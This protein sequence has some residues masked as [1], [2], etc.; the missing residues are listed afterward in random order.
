MPPINCP[1][2]SAFKT[3]QFYFTS[4]KLIPR[5]QERGIGRPRLF[6]LSKH[7]ATSLDVILDIPS[8]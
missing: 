8:S 1:F 4:T 7:V 3:Q 6:K 2:T 5:R